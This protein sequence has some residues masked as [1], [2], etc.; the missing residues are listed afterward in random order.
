MGAFDDL[1]T[2][3]RSFDVYMRV[4]H[5]SPDNPML[6]P[7]AREMWL[8]CQAALDAGTVMGACRTAEERFA[9]A[10]RLLLDAGVQWDEAMRIARDVARK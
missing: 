4:A 10:L 6:K 9:H 2:F 8:A 3:A 7:Q 1:L 5:G